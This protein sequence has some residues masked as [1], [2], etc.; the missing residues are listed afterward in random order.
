MVRIIQKWS[1]QGKKS[2]SVL[3][4]GILKEVPSKL[5]RSLSFNSSNVDDAPHRVRMLTTSDKLS[6]PILGI[7]S[8]LN[9]CGFARGGAGRSTSNPVVQMESKACSTSSVS[10][11]WGEATGSNVEPIHNDSRRNTCDVCVVYGGGEEADVDVIRL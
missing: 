3:S 8:R 11:S 2:C 1:C 7:E 4:R 10:G 6:I 5:N 9:R